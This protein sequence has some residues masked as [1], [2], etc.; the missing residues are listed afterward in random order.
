M[1]RHGR[2]HFSGRPTIALPGLRKR[3]LPVDE[4]FSERVFTYLDCAGAE[5][6]VMVGRSGKQEAEGVGRRMQMQT[7]NSMPARAVVGPC[8]RKLA[9]ML[10]SGAGR[11]PR[12]VLA[13][14]AMDRPHKIRRI[15]GASQLGGAAAHTLIWAFLWAP[16]FSNTRK[17]NTTP[18]TLRGSYP[19]AYLQ[20]KSQ[21]GENPPITP[22]NLLRTL[23]RHPHRSI[24]RPASPQHQQFLD[25]RAQPR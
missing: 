7:E 23:P 8:T 13:P 6:L 15:A 3:R 5:E 11:L 18:T 19:T 21:D 1:S 22:K 12:C 9:L 10:G 4:S 16:G 25:P 24:L 14:Q 17:T 2:S 20:P